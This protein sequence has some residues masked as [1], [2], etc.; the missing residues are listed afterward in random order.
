[1]SE[2][3]SNASKSDGRAL[4]IVIA[5]DDALVRAALAAQLGGRHE[6][7]ATA[8]DGE[9]AAAVVRETRPDVALVDVQMPAGGGLGATREIKQSCPETTVIVLSADESDGVVRDILLAGA[10]TYVRKG[11]AASELDAVLVKSVQAERSGHA[12]TP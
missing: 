6:V 12:D 7:V 8:C 2:P 10:V 5:D 9:E 11:L 1:M 4:R 3:V